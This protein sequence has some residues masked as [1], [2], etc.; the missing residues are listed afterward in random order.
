MKKHIIIF[1]DDRDILDMMD[2]ILA[3]EGYQITACDNLI[4]NETIV[5]FK[6]SLILLDN[7]MGDG[8]GNTLCLA[9]KSDPLTKHIPVVMVSGTVS[10]HLIAE[11]CKADGFLAKPF[12]LN[13]LLDIVKKY[14]ALSITA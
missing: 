4:D 12:D 7:K 3:D 2:M 8:Y 11:R 5:N 6:P 10:L 9:I 1:E 13:E 14:T